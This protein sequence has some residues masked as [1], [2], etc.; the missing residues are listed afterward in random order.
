MV[1]HSQLAKNTKLTENTN[2]L[3]NGQHGTAL[4]TV[5][6]QQQQIAALTGTEADAQKALDAIKAATDHRMGNIKDNA[7]KKPTD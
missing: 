2:Q 7:N 6:A 5:A 3:V 1:D 4:D